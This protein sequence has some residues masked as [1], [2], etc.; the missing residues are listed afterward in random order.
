MG[1]KGKNLMGKIIACLY[2]DGNVFVGGWG[3]EV[4]IDNPRGR[5][6]NGWDSECP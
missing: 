6:E 4:G 1:V 2:T 3:R 5:E